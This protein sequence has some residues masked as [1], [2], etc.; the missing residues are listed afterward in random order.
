MSAKRRA[1]TI[2]RFCVPVKDAPAADEESVGL[3]S[4]LRPPTRPQPQST[5]TDGYEDNAS[6]FAPGDDQSDDSD[7]DFDSDHEPQAKWRKGKG[8]AKVK[9]KVPAKSKILEA[10]RELDGGSNPRVMLISLKGTP[11]LSGDPDALTNF[12]SWSSRPQ[13]DRCKQCF[14]VCNLSF[15]FVY[16]LLIHCCPVWTREPEGTTNLP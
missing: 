10:L 4:R 5:E 12:R 8:K 7:T 9:E 11:F 1:E 3:S 16:H 13:F 14:S 15:R 6:D 2:A